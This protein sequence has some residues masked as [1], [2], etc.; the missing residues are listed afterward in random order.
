MFIRN[1]RAVAMLYGASLPPTCALFALADGIDLTPR[2]KKLSQKFALTEFFF[3][4]LV[5]LSYLLIFA[6]IFLIIKK[7][8][9]DDS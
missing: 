1:V 9:D 3:I 6:L 4:G 5:A 2:K 7:G 8:D